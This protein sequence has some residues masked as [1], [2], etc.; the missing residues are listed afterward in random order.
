MGHPFSS[1][2]LRNR[3]CQVVFTNIVRMR[4]AEP[5]EKKQC[6][7]NKKKKYENQEKESK[8]KKNK[9]MKIERQDKK[10]KE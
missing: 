1:K 5:G 7:G 2:K 10:T 6:H 8:G 4:I 3:A 9:N